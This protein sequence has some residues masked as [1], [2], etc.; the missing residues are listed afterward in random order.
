MYAM[1]FGRRRN[2]SRTALKCHSVNIL[3]LGY[4]CILPNQFGPFAQCSAPLSLRSILLRPRSL[5]DNFDR[6]EDKLCMTHLT[7]RELFTRL[8]PPESSP[9]LQVATEA[10]LMIL[11]I[12]RPRTSLY[13][14]D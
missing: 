10:R 13:H 1:L 4:T 6:L 14:Q 7:I 5:V 9:K 8:D 11:A 2:T 3:L 12:G